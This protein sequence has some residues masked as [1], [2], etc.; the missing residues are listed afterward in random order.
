M[1]KGYSIVL[2]AWLDEC[3]EQKG[4]VVP[5]QT[6]SPLFF[7]LWQIHQQTQVAQLANY[8]VELSNHPLLFGFAQRRLFGS[9]L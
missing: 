2:T 8:L 5:I 9:M 3:C 1:L 7:H 4:Q 6:F